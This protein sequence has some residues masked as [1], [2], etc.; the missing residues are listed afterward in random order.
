MPCR[1]SA[2]RR[3][4]RKTNHTLDGCDEYISEFLWPVHHNVV[5]AGHADELPAPIILWARAELLKRRR[6]PSGGKNVRALP[7]LPANESELLLKCR[8]W[9]FDAHS[10]DP[11]SI[12]S[13]YGKRSCRNW[14]NL[15]PF[16][17]LRGVGSHPCGLLGG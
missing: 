6:P 12:F 4:S 1:T 10:V 14:C 11:G 17:V 3:H 7:H 16:A 9:L 13:V 15:V 2:K 8:Q 5:T